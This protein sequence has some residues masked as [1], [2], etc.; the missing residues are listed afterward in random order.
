MKKYLSNLK[1]FKD[2]IICFVVSSL[3]KFINIR[4]IIFCLLP[5]FVISIHACH[6]IKKKYSRG[7][8][9][10]NG[11]SLNNN[12]QHQININGTLK[13]EE[14]ENGI[15]YNF[16][17]V[18]TD[19]VNEAIASELKPQA[20]YF[21]EK[22][23]VQ[24][25]EKYDKF[26]VS[27]D[28]IS[29]NQ[30]KK[31]SGGKHSNLIPK[32]EL[33]SKLSLISLSISIGF[34]ISILWIAIRFALPEVLIFLLLLNLFVPIVGFLLAVEGD[35]RVKKNPGVFSHENLANLVK[36]LSA[37]LLL[38]NIFLFVIYIMALASAVIW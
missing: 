20:F 37:L 27:S 10:S 11:K 16:K 36:L 26:D 13:K 5:F 35:Y 21:E 31:T 29:K 14:K 4:L 8:Y 9:I 6:P 34:T 28:S 38:T 1:R 33:F 7:Y 3:F 19:T 2:F 23:S 24:L 18:G 15:C 25:F 12:K 17:Y 30:Q 22:N 32:M